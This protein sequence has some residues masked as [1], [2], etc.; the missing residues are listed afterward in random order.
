MT[1][2]LVPAD[3]HLEKIRQAI[4]NRRVVAMHY[5]SP[6]SGEFTERA[7]EPVGT[8][9]YGHAWHVIAYCRLRNDYR[10]FRL[11]RMSKV[12][13]TS[14]MYQRRD[15]Q[16]LERYLERQSQTTD[17]TLVKV[18][19]ALSAVALVQTQRYPFGFVGE[20]VADDRTEMWFLVA[21][22]EPFCRW[23]LTH[24]DAV[25]AVSPPRLYD[26]VQFLR[27]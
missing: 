16:S 1:P 21:Q 4:T 15:R 8:V 18:C 3:V 24:G 10:D 13:I 2:H 11:D 14:E 6:G 19:F 22:E 25:T 5:F 26:T 9:Y 12:S 20:T 23:L 27:N 7:I 17:A